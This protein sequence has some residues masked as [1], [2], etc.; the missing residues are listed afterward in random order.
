MAKWPNLPTVR[1]KSEPAVRVSRATIIFHVQPYNTKI[2]FS[3]VCLTN[4]VF[5]FF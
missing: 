2:C 4:I 5:A 3:N 1:D